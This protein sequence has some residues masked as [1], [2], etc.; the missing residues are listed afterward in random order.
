MGALADALKELDEGK[1]GALVETM[2][3][4]GVGVEE[5]I[6]ECTSGL[7]S[8]GELF[9]QGQYFLTELIFAGEIMKGVMD[10][11]APLMEAS[12]V[13]EGASGTVVIGTVEGDIHDIGKNIVTKLLRCHGFNVVDLGVD[14]PADRFVEAVRETGAKVLGLSA[15]LNSTYPEMKK[16]V[17][18]ITEAGLRDQVKIIIG[19]TIVNERVREFTGAD[20]WANDAV[21][22]IDIIRSIYG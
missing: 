4:D 15:L 2:L 9:S 19:G 20:Y 8:V 10:R 22:G 6:R 5:I 17:D 16:V 7:V 1:V 11:L 14:V 21:K 12:G 13:S 3:K 18:K